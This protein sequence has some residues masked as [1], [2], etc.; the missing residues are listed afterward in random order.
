MLVEMACSRV[1][2]CWGDEDCAPALLTEWCLRNKQLPIFGVLFGSCLELISVWTSHFLAAVNVLLGKAGGS[3]GCKECPGL[4]RE[5]GARNARAGHLERSH[6]SLPVVTQN[7]LMK[8]P[9]PNCETGCTGFKVLTL[10]HP[11]K[12]TAGGRKTA[13]WPALSVT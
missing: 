7:F 4:S 5:G 3:W 6:H 9:S 11:C 12:A 10:E 8:K 13:Q 1:V 2:L